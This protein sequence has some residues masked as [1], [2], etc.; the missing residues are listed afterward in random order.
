MDSHGPQHIKYIDHEQ[1][2]THL[3]HPVFNAIWVSTLSI[4]MLLL[5]I[6]PLFLVFSLFGRRRDGLEPPA[7]EL[8]CCVSPLLPHLLDMQDIEGTWLVGG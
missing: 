1:T 5:T 4:D 3:F 8:S 6:H 7:T 2:L